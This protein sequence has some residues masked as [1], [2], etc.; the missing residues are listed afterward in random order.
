MNKKLVS[1]KATLLTLFAAVVSSAFLLGKSLTSVN[2][3]FQ[4][5]TIC[6]GTGNGTY[7]TITVDNEG[8]L[9]GHINH[10]ANLGDLI[11]APNGVCPEPTATATGSPEPSGTPQPTIDPC[12]GPCPTA[13]ATPEASATPEPTVNPDVCLNLDGIQTG[14]PEGLHLGADQTSCVAFSQAGPPQRNDEGTST[15]GQVLGAS[16]MAGTGTFTE[17]LYQAIMGLGG[18][19][20]F[21]GFKS[22]KISKKK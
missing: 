3:T 7:Q 8:E 15:T 1:G 12:D 14:V 19:L 2:A 16:T 4:S 13:T 5:V 21:K 17:T 9:N 20:S 11:P 18:L 22:L 10:Q 6:H